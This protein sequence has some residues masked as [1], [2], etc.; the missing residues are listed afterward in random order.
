MKDKIVST[1]LIPFDKVYISCIFE[2]NRN[3]AFEI[4]KQFNNVEVGGIGIN[5][6]KLSKEIEHLMPDYETFDCDYSLGFTTRGC[7]RKCEFCKV[8]KHEG[9]IKENCDIYEFW[10]PKHK[11]IV[12]LD[13]NIFAL[14]EHFKK[15]CSQIK[16]EELKVDFNQGL[17]C[18]LLDK[19]KAKILSSIP[20]SEYRFAFDSLIVEPHVKK[21]IKLLKSV[22]I[23]RCLW[24]VLVGFNTTFEQDLYRLNLLRDLNQ[25]VYVQRYNS[26]F[27]DKRH[28][29]LARWGNQHH[30]FQAMTW[31]QF[32]NRSENRRY[33]KECETVGDFT[34]TPSPLRS[35]GNLIHVTRLRSDSPLRRESP[36]RPNDFPSE[37]HFG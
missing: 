7:I 8:P 30:I 18:R 23:N 2:Q 9:M 17:D 3:T 15:I 6:I 36:L 32:I 14:P 12:L 13:N 24:Y 37:N 1:R 35:S 21:A 22:G 19:Q 31:K 25:N 29:A 20:H 4:A 34:L 16:S 5:N 11:Q 33:K 10:N 28:I 26:N 27:T